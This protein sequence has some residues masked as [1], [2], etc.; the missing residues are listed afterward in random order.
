M[1][2]SVK[3]L[4]TRSVAGAKYRVQNEITTSSGIPRELFVKRESTYEYDRIATLNDIL[5]LPTSPDPKL[6]YFRD[7]EFIKDFDDVS[8]ADL[9]SKGI[10]DRLDRTMT[11][12]DLAINTFTGQDHTLITSA[13]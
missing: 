2:A 10:K 1:V 13:D 9:F 4:Q 12:Y 7:Y 8:E 6:G 3:L 5:T 11:V